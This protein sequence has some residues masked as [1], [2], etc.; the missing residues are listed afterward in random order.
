MLKFSACYEFVPGYYLIALDYF[1]TVIVLS[2]S[3]TQEAHINII[4]LLTKYIARTKYC[5]MIAVPM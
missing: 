5:C 4:V 1:D 2:N 3:S